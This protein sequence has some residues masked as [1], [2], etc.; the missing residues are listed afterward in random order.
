MKNSLASNA[1]DTILTDSQRMQLYATAGGGC[2]TTATASNIV[3]SVAKKKN[4]SEMPGQCQSYISRKKA[5]NIE[6]K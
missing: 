2:Q 5:K 4:G 1:T 3:S 6:V